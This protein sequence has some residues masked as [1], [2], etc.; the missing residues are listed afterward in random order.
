MCA[1]SQPRFCGCDFLNEETGKFQICGPMNGMCPKCYAV[2]FPMVSVINSSTNDSTN[3]NNQHLRG[4]SSS[5]NSSSTPSFTM[6][7]NNSSPSSPN[8]YIIPPELQDF[9]HTA[10]YTENSFRIV[11]KIGAG[12]GG[13]VF[14]AVLD[15]KSGGEGKRGDL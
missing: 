15:R 8:Y 1:R 13:E 5:S 14:E 4:V 3:N 9:P 2:C 6:P 10:I 7:S 11:K 12:A